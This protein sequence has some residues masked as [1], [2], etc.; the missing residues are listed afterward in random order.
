MTRNFDF[1]DTISVVIPGA[2]AVILLLFFYSSSAA[3]FMQFISALSVGSSLVFL[4]LSYAIGELLQALGKAMVKDEG[5]FGYQE[6][7]YT[8]V[9]QHENAQ[10]KYKNFLNR[11]E[12]QQVRD[13]LSSHFGWDTISETQLH[14]CFYH[15]KVKVYS[16]DVYRAECIKMLTKLHFFSTV[17]ALSVLSPVMYVA[18]TLMADSRFSL[19]KF[20]LIFLLSAIG[21]YGSSKCREDFD[22]NYN[23]C[24]FSSYLAIVESEKQ[25]P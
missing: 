22:N 15:I 3:Q 12:C 17:M 19:W 24:L 20:L 5:I 4:V 9:L 14:S 25:T 16:H 18:I 21:G 8:K 23:R 1:H 13:A 11:E 7:A 2:C 6:A 10:E